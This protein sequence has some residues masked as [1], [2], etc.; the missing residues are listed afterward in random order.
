MDRTQSAQRDETPSWPRR[1]AGKTIFTTSDSCV[2]ASRVCS[3]TLT[4][5]SHDRHRDALIPRPFTPRLEPICWPQ[6]AA[7]L[8]AVYVCHF[9]RN[10]SANKSFRK[11]RKR[12]RVPITMRN[13]IVTR[14]VARAS[15]N[16][17]R[18]TVFNSRKL[19]LTGGEDRRRIFGPRGSAQPFDKA[20][21]G[22]GNQRKSKGFFVAFPGITRYG[23]RESG[24]GQNK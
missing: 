18:C 11:T 1:R 10:S 9:G 12:G 15:G 2:P 6:E 17:Q 23:A 21:F 13:S 20:R 3:M 24:E 19:L 8:R 4:W 14:R 22:K 16:G 5:R 7:G